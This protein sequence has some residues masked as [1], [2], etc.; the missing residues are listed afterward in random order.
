MGKSILIIDKSESFA[1]EFTAIVGKKK[2]IVHHASSSIDGIHLL[3]KEI[4]LIVI[5]D[6]V[7]DSMSGFDI[8]KYIKRDE[9]LKQILV[10]QYSS[11][12]SGKHVFYAQNSGVDCFFNKKD[13]GIEELAAKCLD[14]LNSSTVTIEKKDRPVL[15]QDEILFKIDAFYCD[16][17]LKDILNDSLYEL[18]SS[19]ESIDHLIENFFTMLN[20]FFLVTTASI[21]FTTKGK[22]TYYEKST[23]LSSTNSD[24]V[25][26]DIKTHLIKKNRIS[27]IEN[28]SFYKRKFSHF[29]DNT[30]IS[31]EIA[32]KENY[33]TLF[34]NKSYIILY[35]RHFFQT[36]DEYNYLLYVISI[37][38][39]ILLQACNY[40]D[41]IH[42]I[43]TIRYS[44]SKFLP[45]KIID[46]L[47]RKK[48]IGESQNFG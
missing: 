24:T 47:M 42:T 30:Y 40:H 31:N 15:T 23:A 16:L 26:N 20:T 39:K 19:V 41:E 25:F 43:Q 1:A 32:D 6:T 35:V 12:V 11:V 34:H 22:Y 9:I 18:C 29:T 48:S 45:E 38:D 44:F 33:F 4:P 17:M 13:V 3:F 2:Y 5:V 8:V 37:F 46:D 28:S 10:I 21:L 14:T 27:Q 36:D 7:I